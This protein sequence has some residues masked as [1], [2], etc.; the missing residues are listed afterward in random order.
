MHVIY[1]YTHKAQVSATQDSSIAAGKI[2][3]CNASTYVLVKDTLL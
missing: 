1:E 3:Y 2:V